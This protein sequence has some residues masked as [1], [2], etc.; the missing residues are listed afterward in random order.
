[1]TI[2]IGEDLSDYDT[3]KVLR[4]VTNSLVNALSLQEDFLLPCPS[5]AKFQAY[6]LDPGPNQQVTS[7]AANQCRSESVV[8]VNPTNPM[9]LICASKKFISPQLYTFTIST[10]FST[11]GGAHWTESPLALQPGWQG[12]T[13]PD[14]TFD[15]A[16]NAYLIAEAD[17]FA[18][19][20]NVTAIGMFVFKTVD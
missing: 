6:R 11:D 3:S 14:L 7:S 17:T 18:A 5:L 1:M 9:N 4:D 16:G 19:G 15:A 20:G 8:G 2:S 10:S 12:M 13:D